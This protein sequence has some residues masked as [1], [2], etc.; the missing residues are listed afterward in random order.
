MLP[1]GSMMFVWSFSLMLVMLVGCSP[2]IGIRGRVV[3]YNNIRLD[4]MKLTYYTISKDK[5]EVLHEGTA[6]IRPTGDFTIRVTQQKRFPYW[7]II[8]GV[9][10]I[11]ESSVENNSCEIPHS[12]VTNVDMGDVYIYDKIEIQGDFSH[13]IRL[14]DLRFHWKS[15][16]PSVD[17]YKVRLI[18]QITVSGI[19]GN[20]FSFEDIG[21]SPEK[22]GR[23]RGGDLDITVSSARNE[24]TFLLDVE[25]VRLIR[26]KPVIVGRA[27][28]RTVTIA[29]GLAKAGSD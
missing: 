13:P 15:N 9:D 5:G 22:Q 2:Q 19:K 26:G 28:Q 12:K 27:A 25:A 10:T 24:G 17:F 4:G 6:R 29:R 3:S 1:I 11:P 16:I 8:S 21:S 23:F 20:S 7:L 18:G 14:R